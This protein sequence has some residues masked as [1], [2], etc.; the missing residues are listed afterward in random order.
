M[1]VC[2]SSAISHALFTIPTPASSGVESFV[3]WDRCSAP[4]V[5]RPK[6]FCQWKPEISS[7]ARSS[8]SLVCA[9]SGAPEGAGEPEDTASWLSTGAGALEGVAPPLSVGEGSAEGSTPSL[10]SGEGSAEGSPP[11]LSSGEGSAEGAT[12][13]LPSGAGSAEGFTPS[14]S[15]GALSSGT[16]GTAG[17]WLSSGVWLSSGCPEG[18]A[19]LTGACVGSEPA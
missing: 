5:V 9:I 10:S 7:A 15:A 8:S 2:P 6:L 11:S 18:A 17:A 13:S 16:R 4:S 12:S 3:A 14:L 1:A 19:L